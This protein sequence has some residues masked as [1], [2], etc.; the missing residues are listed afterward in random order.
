MNNKQAVLIL[1]IVALLSVLA[2][3]F[4]FIK[5][6]QTIEGTYSTT[7]STKNGV[8]EHNDNKVL[9]EI[10]HTGN[11]VVTVNFW[12]TENPGFLTGFVLEGTDGTYSTGA[13]AQKLLFESTPIKLNKGSNYLTFS[14]LASND[15][16]LDFYEKTHFYDSPGEPWDGFMDGE[17]DMEYIYIVR[18]S[19]SDLAVIIGI[20]LSVFALCVAFI[21]SILLRKSNKPFGDYDERQLIARYK[22]N[23]HGFFVTLIGLLFSYVLISLDANGCVETSVLILL[24]ALLG[25][26]VMAVEGILKD[27]YYSL[28][29]NRKSYMIIFSLMAVILIGASVVFLVKGLVIVDGVITQNIA[30]LLIAT[31]LIVILVTTFIKGKKDDMED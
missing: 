3:A 2:G 30:P 7:V 18:R 28:N 31:L 9:L 6:N 25:I 16:Y 11:Y 5:C 20:S 19:F 17:T 10:N 12:P 8:T 14:F 13:T 21:V 15:E 24:P 4:L 29:D 26:G 27:G 1:E 22:S 23:T